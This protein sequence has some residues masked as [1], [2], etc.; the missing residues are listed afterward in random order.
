M[1]ICCL[2]KF[3][4]QTNECFKLQES[5]LHKRKVFINFFP[6][7]LETVSSIFKTDMGCN[8]QGCLNLTKLHTALWATFMLTF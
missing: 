1:E 2:A 7:T 8:F 4:K 5:S 3:P 6:A